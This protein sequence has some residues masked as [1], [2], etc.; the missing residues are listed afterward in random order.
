MASANPSTRLALVD[1]ARRLMLERGY[2]AT[3]L[4]QVCAAAGV[5]KGAFFHYFKTKEALGQ[6]VLA[7][8][9]E[10]SQQ[11]YRD[12]P[13]LS[14]TDPLERLLGYVEFTASLVRHPVRDACLF[15]MFSQELAASEPQFRLG[16]ASAFAQWAGGLKAMLEDARQR[17][18]PRA[19]ISVD[20]AA[21]HFIA[22]F[23]GALILAKAKGDPGTVKVHLDLYKRWL[24]SLFTPDQRRKR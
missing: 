14:K 18:A 19:R 21:E 16:C 7:R 9:G 24:K 4:D 10:L 5:S 2:S 3:T 22:V 11:A 13:F 20:E 23:E 15:G 8:H 1:Q 17:H 12:A 6:A